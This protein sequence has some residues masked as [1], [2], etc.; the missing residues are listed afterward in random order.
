MPHDKHVKN[1]KSRA[2]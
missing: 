2:M 1:T